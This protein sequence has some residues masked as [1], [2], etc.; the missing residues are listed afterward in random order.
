MSTPNC[1]TCGALSTDLS[2]TQCGYCGQA[3][4]RAEPAY[5]AAPAPPYGAASPYGGPPVQPFGAPPQGPHGG[6][7]GGYGVPVQPFGGNY[8]PY[9]VPRQNGFWST[10][11]GVGNALFWIRLGIALFVLSVV[12]AS[13]CITALS[14]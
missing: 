4:R 14:Q 10:I 1:S 11:N 8:A 5:A 7:H 2:A 12:A 13:S 6:A 3:L 9:A